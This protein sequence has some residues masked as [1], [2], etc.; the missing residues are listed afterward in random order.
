MDSFYSFSTD[1]IAALREVIRKVRH[2][3]SNTRNRLADEDDTVTAPEVY[4]VRTPESGING[5]TAVGT[6][7]PPA[8]ETLSG[9]TCPLYRLNPNTLELESMGYTKV[10]Y[11]LSAV[12]GNKWVIADRDKYGSWWAVTTETGGSVTQG[13]AIVQ[14]TAVTLTTIT[15][16]G[17]TA[18]LKATSAEIE[19][20]NNA[21]A[22]WNVGSQVWFIGLNSETPEINGR[23][24]V[25]FVGAD[26]NGV[27]I[28]ATDI[29]S[30]GAV[31]TPTS[32]TSQ[33]VTPVNG[34]NIQAYSAT[35]SGSTSAWV[36]STIG[37]VLI[38]G[39]QY[40]G[41]AVNTDTSGKIVYQVCQ[42][43]ATVKVTSLT[44]QTVSLKTGESVSA[45]PATSEVLAAPVGTGT[46]KE[47]TGLTGWFYPLNGEVPVLDHYYNCRLAAFSTSNVPV[48][49]TELASVSTAYAI[50][51]ENV[52]GTQD[53]VVM[54][55]GVIQTDNLVGASY[56]NSY[57]FGRI[58]VS[59]VTGNTVKLDW[60]GLRVYSAGL[61]YF[62][63]EPD[64]EIDG[65]TCTG[66]S[67]QTIGVSVTNDT[68]DQ[69]VK[70]TLYT[71]G[72]TMTLTIPLCVGGTVNPTTCV[73]TP[74]YRHLT[75]S[76]NCG[77]L[78]SFG[79]GTGSGE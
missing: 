37:D 60:Q 53:A 12:A 15:L 23:Y 42:E 72:D 20:L 76:F 1:D 49:A 34:S 19:T 55:P 18:T 17:G 39:Q 44:P 57:A 63:P 28:V 50:T 36:Q 10:V 61:G 52:G 54:P 77:L 74:I 3:S 26:E 46:S 73:F 40:V 43:T 29:P 21:N 22:L 9:A 56:A 13:T 11:S 79:S 24:F 32:A 71:I 33:S 68:T 59:I 45:Y 6:G 78:Q 14:V 25:A 48:W 62:G 58:Q 30:D 27:P 67:G 66:G 75:L 7:S 38:V 8:T 16:P 35:A 4:V 65:G 2:G 70:V 64:L 31:V 47:L 41:Q 51:V 5:P 69:R